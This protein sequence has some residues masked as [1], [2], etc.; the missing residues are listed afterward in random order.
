MTF[1][2]ATNIPLLTARVLLDVGRGEGGE[3]E[4][5]CIQIVTGQRS[6][7]RINRLDLLCGVLGG[8][9]ADWQWR[10]RSLPGHGAVQCVHVGLPSFSS[11]L[12]ARIV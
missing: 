2:L 6:R 8:V 9:L 5:D 3:C 12:P 11:C 1:H 10:V 7:Q 4:S